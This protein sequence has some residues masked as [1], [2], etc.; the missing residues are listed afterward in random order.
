MK[1]AAVVA[2]YNRRELLKECLQALLSQ[3]RPPDEIIVVDGNSIDGTD[4]MMKSEFPHVTYIRL[5]K[6]MGASGHFYEGMKLAYKKGYD[7]I[8]VMD[9]D[10][11]P[12]ENT[13]E[14]L[15]KWSDLND[16]VALAPVVRDEDMSIQIEHRGNLCFDTIF[17]LIQKPLSHKEYCSNTPLMITFTSFVGPLINCK[18]ISKIGFPRKEF[19]IYHDDVEYSMRLTRVGKIYLIP[20]AYIIH[21]IKRRKSKRSSGKKSF[22]IPYEDIWI[23]YY[24][25]RNIIYLGK[26]YSTNKLKFIIDAS[27]LLSRLIVRTILFED[28]KLRRLLF[29]LS[30]YIDGFRGVFDNAKP[31]KILY[32]NKY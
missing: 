25:F 1:I 5:D 8:W 20:K 29:F 14:E 31:K 28:Y 32:G 27:K 19:F 17:P 21:K 3:T 11:E 16:V 6:N 10:A 7:W 13:L 15:I 12:E 2:T 23:R 18:A 22:I 9:D 30:A 26:L 24:A 4:L